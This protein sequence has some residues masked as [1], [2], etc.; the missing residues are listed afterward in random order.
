MY[1]VQT[2]P[3]CLELVGGDGQNRVAS[4]VSMTSGTQ[5]RPRASANRGSATESRW[6]SR[7]SLGRQPSGTRRARDGERGTKSGHP[8][9]PTL[10]SAGATRSI[11]NANGVES[12]SPGLGRGTRPTLGQRTRPPP[13]ATRLWRWQAFASRQPVRQYRQTI[14]SWMSAMVTS[15]RLP[16]FFSWVERLRALADLRTSRSSKDARKM[17]VSSIKPGMM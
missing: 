17:G 4:G 12:H 15:T 8:G 5:G 13:T 11:T 6:D 10:R 14:T 16:R 9:S 2:R 3:H 1:N 7:E